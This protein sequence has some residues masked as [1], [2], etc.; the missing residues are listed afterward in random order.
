LESEVAEI[1]ALVNKLEANLKEK[2]DQYHF[3][4]SEYTELMEK[5]AKLKKNEEA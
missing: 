2:E 5:A 1:D 4:I 3:L